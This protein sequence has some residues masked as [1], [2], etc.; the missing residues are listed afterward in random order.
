[1]TH[2]SRQIRVTGVPCALLLTHAAAA[3]AQNADPAPDTRPSFSVSSG[4][5]ATSREKPAIYLTFRRLDHLDF[6]VYRVNDPVAFLSGLKDPAPARQRRAARRPDADAARAHR[7][8][9]GRVARANPQ[10]LAGAIQLRLPPPAPR[11]QH[12]SADRRPPPDGQRQHVRAGAGAERV[13][14]RDVLA[15]DPA[16]AARHRRAPHSDRRH[17]ARHVRCRG[18]AASAPGVHGRHRLR[19]R[20]GEQG[21]AGP[22][23][24]CSRPIA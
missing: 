21:R 19:R 3:T 15:R 10:L 5:I 16:A 6:R 12:G 4:T 11:C 17:G 2:V 22:D 7:G 24:C 23:R 13:A 9:E 1:M 14:A 20:P 8:L 18:R